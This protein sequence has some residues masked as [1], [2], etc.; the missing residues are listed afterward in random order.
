[1]QRKN[2]G[3]SNLKVSPLGFG[4]F[5][6]EG[7]YGPVKDRN[8]S[9]ET[10]RHAY[11]LG[12]NFFDT[13]NNYG[14]GSNEKLVRDAL[15]DYDDVIISTK[16]GFRWDG[17]GIRADP[18]YVR[19]CVDGSLKRLSTSAIDLLFLHRVDKKTPIEETV[20]AMSD[21]VSEGKVRYIGLSEA[22]AE[23]IKRANKIHPITAVQTEYSILSRDVEGEILGACKSLGISFIPYSPFAHGL[24]TGKINEQKD[25]GGEWLPTEPRFHGVAFENNV[26]LLK[27]IKDV[28]KNLSS[29]PSQVALAWL[30]EQQK[31][32][33]IQM[34]PIPGTRTKTH[35][36]ENVAGI[37]L[38]LDQNTLDNLDS[39]ASQV[40]GERYS[41]DLMAL[42]NL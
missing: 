33:G 34:I 26:R 5:G 14:N 37:N 35:L 15:S 40:S 8:D 28:A 29:T 36:D 11:R 30:F 20:G 31:K 16:F 17:K 10:I 12:I 24:L 21:L 4:C 6:L 39:L 41:P 27:E 19:E 32:S 1:M 22:G 18:A 13:S 9:I 25:V 38:I 42:S 2:L 3:K 23:T 7:V